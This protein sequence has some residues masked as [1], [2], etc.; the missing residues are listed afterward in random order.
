MDL[1]GVRNVVERP[2]PAAPPV[3]ATRDELSRLI[4]AKLQQSSSSG[5]LSEFTEEVLP[6]L[7]KFLESPEEKRLRRIRTGSM[8]SFIGLGIAVGFLIAGLIADDELIA[9]AAA[10][11]IVF[12]IGIA[13]IVNGVYFT[14]PGAKPQLTDR[15]PKPSLGDEASTTNELLMPPSANQEFTSVTENTT[16][17]LKNK[18]LESSAKNKI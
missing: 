4:A 3:T 9:A 18:D 12:F 1:R 17:Q 2:Q 7:E 10:G 8:V 11:F 16:R 6:E 13:L 14:V 15:G 5:E